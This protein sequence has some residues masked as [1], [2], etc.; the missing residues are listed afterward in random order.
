MQRF[1]THSQKLLDIIQQ[2]DTAIIIDNSNKKPFTPIFVL[3]NKH[4]INFTTCP[5][6]LKNIHQAIQQTHPEQTIQQLLKLHKNIDMKK[7]TDE[8]RE[9][10]GQII[11]AS[12]LKPNT[13]HHTKNNWLE[14]IKIFFSKKYTKQK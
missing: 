12:L 10:F 9:N 4:L 6:Y 3:S 8:Q 14:R 2:E 13:I 1:E 5:E 11:L 7:L